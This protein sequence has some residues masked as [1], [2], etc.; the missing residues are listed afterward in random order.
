MKKI[1]LK[2]LDEENGLRK[3]QLFYLITHNIVTMA[4][5]YGLLKYMNLI[6]KY[7]NMKYEIKFL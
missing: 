4:N 6:M 2:E 7:E 5:Q 3:E 1:L